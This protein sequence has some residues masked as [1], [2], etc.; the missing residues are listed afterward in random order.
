[1]QIKFYTRSIGPFRLLYDLLLPFLCR[2]MNDRVYRGFSGFTKGLYDAELAPSY[3]RIAA[4]V[5]AF[6]T[7]QAG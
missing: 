4:L 5:E 2:G 3:A 1:M 7:D 6:M